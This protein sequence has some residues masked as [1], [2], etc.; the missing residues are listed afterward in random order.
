MSNGADADRATKLAKI[1]ALAAELAVKRTGWTGHLNKRM[2]PAQFREANVLLGFSQDEAATWLGI[3]PSAVE[4]YA[5]GN[6][7]VPQPTA[8]LLR[9]VIK[10]GINPQDVGMRHG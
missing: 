3:S 4:A 6:M 2:S 8:M 1:G 9:L 7:P 10:L 5:L